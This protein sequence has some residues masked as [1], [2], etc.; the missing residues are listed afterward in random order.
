MER[1]GSLASKPGGVNWTGAVL[2]IA[3]LHAN[4]IKMIEIFI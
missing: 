4:S 2:G 1:N 3:A